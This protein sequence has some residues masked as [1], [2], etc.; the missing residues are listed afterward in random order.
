[1][2]AT[3]EAPR[4]HDH[5]GS[6]GVRNQ[7]WIRRKFI[8][9]LDSVLGAVLLTDCGVSSRP[10]RRSAGA[11]DFWTFRSRPDLRPTKIDLQAPRSSPADGYVLSRLVD[12][13]SSTSRET[14]SGSGRHLL[15]TNLKVQQ[16]H[17]Q[18]VLT[19]WEGRI[20]HYGVGR[21]GEAVVLDSHYT[22]VASI[23]AFNGLQ[24]DLH[25]FTI[26]PDGIAYLTAYQ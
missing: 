14:R 5:L 26:V 15:V 17:G 9:V 23:R 18:P 25:A 20:T 24:A 16:L 4:R 19:W 3:T 7:G 13:S 21:S 8:S 1:V 22:E 10:S 6:L 12:L 2:S 11:S